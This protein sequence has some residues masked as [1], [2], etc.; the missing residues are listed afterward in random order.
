ME[1]I[2]LAEETAPAEVDY[3]VGDWIDLEALASLVDSDAR[4]RVSFGVEDP[5]LTVTDQ[6]VT[7]DGTT[8]RF[9]DLHKR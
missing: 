7:I 3:R 2:G 9:E 8:Y 6:T 1:A 4:D 5:E